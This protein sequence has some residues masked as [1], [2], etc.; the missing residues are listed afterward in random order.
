MS[1]VSKSK[2]Y[3]CPPEESGAPSFDPTALSAAVARWKLGEQ[4]FRAAQAIPQPQRQPYLALACAGD[5][6]LLSEL[7]SM[8][9]FERIYIAA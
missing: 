3:V 9:A 8:L 6:K 4:L 1:D 5:D 7:E 2:V